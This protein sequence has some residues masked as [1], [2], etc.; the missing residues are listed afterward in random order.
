MLKKTIIIL[1]TVFFIGAAAVLFIVADSIKKQGISDYS[2]VYRTEDEV[3]TEGLIEPIDL[4]SDT[5]AVVDRDGYI[6]LPDNTILENLEG[7]RF[8]T[9]GLSFAVP[10]AWKDHVAI[11][12][13]YTNQGGSAGVSENPVYS[14]LRINF[15]EKETFDRLLSNKTGQDST[16][17]MITSIVMAEESRNDLSGYNNDPSWQYFGKLERN[18]KTYRL[19]LYQTSGKDPYD[20]TDSKLYKRLLQ[21]DF[22]GCVI[23]TATAYE[24]K[25]TFAN[26]YVSKVVQEGFDPGGDGIKEGSK[27]PALVKDTARIREQGTYSD[28]Y[29]G[30]DSYEWPEYAIPWKYQDHGYMYPYRSVIDGNAVQ[31]EPSQPQPVIQQDPEEEVEVAEEAAQTDANEEFDVYTEDEFYDE[32]PYTED[33]ETEWEAEGEDEM[34]IVME[35]SVTIDGTEDYSNDNEEDSEE[36]LEEG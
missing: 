8:R 21:T 25:L 13:I 30:L 36:I 31:W 24:G 32:E 29:Y 20:T 6:H 23:S 12:D 9:H 17:G 1:L 10:G 26:S 18:G 15:Y 34:E 7:T 3:E 14:T 33:G 28:I 35:D 16:D 27:L 5:S 2:D 22:A 19:Y 4:Y 11:R